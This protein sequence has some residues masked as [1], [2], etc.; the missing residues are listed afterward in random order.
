MIF[1]WMSNLG[2]QYLFIS[3]DEGMAMAIVRA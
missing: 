3:D 1:L 2:I